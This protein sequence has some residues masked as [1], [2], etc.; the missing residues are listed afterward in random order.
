LCL[1]A[2]SDVLTHEKKMKKKDN[3]KDQTKNCHR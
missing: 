1:M 2:A 3:P